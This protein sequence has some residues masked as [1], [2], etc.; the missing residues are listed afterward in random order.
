M[1]QVWRPNKCEIFS[2][3]YMTS[4]YLLFRTKKSRCKLSTTEI[5]FATRSSSGKRKGKVR[6][7]RHREDQ[8]S[9]CLVDQTATRLDLPLLR[10]L[11][12]DSELE[13]KPGR[14]WTRDQD[15]PFQALRFFHPGAP[16]WQTVHVS[17]CLTKCPKHSLV[18]TPKWRS[19]VRV[20]VL[21]R[22]SRIYTGRSPKLV[23]HACDGT[24]S[25]ESPFP[26][27]LVYAVC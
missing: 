25:T 18:Q 13:I 8:A 12:C 10:V 22:R 19:V 2:S 3:F 24:P 17:Q 23:T 5:N 20:F 7:L 11:Y 14:H 4:I 15:M 9:W 16:Q 27:S 1:C 21:W 6:W 26:W